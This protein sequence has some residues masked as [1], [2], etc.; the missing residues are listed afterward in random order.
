MSK[1][2]PKAKANSKRHR[3]RNA[4]IKSQSKPPLKK[5][6]HEQQQEKPTLAEPPVT[7][8]PY[9]PGTLYATLFTE[10]N[11]EY[12]SKTDLIKKVAELT[13]KSEKV[14][15]FAYQVLKSPSHR[16]NKKRSRELTE[17]DKVI[18]VAL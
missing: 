15:T 2:K 1:T 16:S 5:P 13:G 17:A 3:A 8:C 7:N 6:V 10:G 11:R 18:L 4:K 9:R 12:I 14:V